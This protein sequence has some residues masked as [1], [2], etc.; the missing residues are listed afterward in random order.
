MA[1]LL[2]RKKGLCRRQ[3]QAGQG[4]EVDGTGRRSR[5]SAGSSVGKCHS[6]RS[7]TCGG[8]ARRSFGSAAPRPPAAKAGTGDCR[9]RLRFRSAART[10][11]ET[12]HRVDRAVPGEQSAPALR[13]WA[14]IAPLQAALDRRTHQLLAGPVPPIAGASSASALHLPRL[15]LY[16][17]LLDYSEALFMKYALLTDQ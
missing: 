12:R 8:H 14:Q 5:S 11:E 15:L 2:R 13:R 10:T 9:H 3:N 6:A 4:D 1:A 16:R 17:V 7:Y